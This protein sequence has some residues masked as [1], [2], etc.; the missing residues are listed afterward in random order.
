MLFCMF[1]CGGRQGRRLSLQPPTM[2]PSARTPASFP[3]SSSFRFAAQEPAQHPTRATRLRGRRRH[4]R[5]RWI[6]W[7]EGPLTWSDA[8]VRRQPLGG[9]E[10]LGDVGGPQ[11]P[12]RQDQHLQ[13]NAANTGSQVWVSIASAAS[14]M[15]RAGVSEDQLCSGQF[16]TIPKRTITTIL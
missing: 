16:R 14:A 8:D 12:G 6:G 2:K 7:L 3:A 9:E 5:C 11:Q 10:K 15:V 4:V 13:R 1:T